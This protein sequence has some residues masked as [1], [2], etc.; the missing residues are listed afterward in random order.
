MANSSSD[1]YTPAFITPKIDRP[2][3]ADCRWHL[4]VHYDIQ[5]CDKGAS[6]PMHGPPIILCDHHQ[7]EIAAGIRWVSPEQS[8]RDIHER[9]DR[10]ARTK[11]AQQNETIDHLRSCLDEE[12]NPKRNSKRAPAPA[13]GQVYFLLSDNLVKIGWTGDLDQR[14]KQYSPG[15]RILAVKPGT[16]QDETALHKKFADLRTNRREWFTYH[17]RVMEEADRTTKAHGKPPRE[18]NEPMVTNQIVGPRLASYT[19]RRARSR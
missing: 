12:R 3:T 14:M 15:A 9:A 11:L 18:L 5:L 7:R 8:K 6:P 13:V 4:L 16:K 1:R 10:V 19:Q 17:P 2:N